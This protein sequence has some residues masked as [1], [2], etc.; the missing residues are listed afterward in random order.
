[1]AM[2]ENTIIYWSDTLPQCCMAAKKIHIGILGYAIQN[3]E[4]LK[5]MMQM[6]DYCHIYLLLIQNIIT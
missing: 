1:M 4:T 2:P 3:T 6:H 5:K